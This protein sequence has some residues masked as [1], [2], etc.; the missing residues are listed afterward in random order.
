MSCSFNAFMLVAIAINVMSKLATCPHVRDAHG[1]VEVFIEAARARS[2][3]LTANPILIT[4]SSGRRDSDTRTTDCHRSAV[5]TWKVLTPG[6][7]AEELIAF[8]IWVGF[9]VFVQI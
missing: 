9:W 5:R 4:S 2:R 8:L 7:D 1:R 3:P 6:A